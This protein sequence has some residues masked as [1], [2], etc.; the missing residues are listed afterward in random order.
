MIGFV[1]RAWIAA[2]LLAAL[3]AVA[4]ADAADG[5][6][7]VYAEDEALRIGATIQRQLD[8]GEGP[9]MGEAGIDSVRFWLSWSDVE[10]RHDQYDWGPVDQVVRQIATGGLT[11]VPF[12]FGSPEWSARRDGF[13]CSAPKCVPYAPSTP[14]TRAEFAEFAAIAVRRYG[15]GGTFWEHNIGIPYRPIGIWQVWNEPNL[16]AFYEPYVSPGRYAEL[17][18]AT[19]AAIRA[20]DA[21]AEVVLAGLSGNRTTSTHWSTQEYL[22]A[23]Y[24]VP[25]IEQSF[26]GIAIHP[27]AS[28]VRGVMQRIATAREIA[29]AEDPGAEL[30]VTEIGWASGGPK[31]WSLVKTPRLQARLLRRS[32][33]RLIR[34]T[35]EW[36]LRGIYWYA[37]R[38]TPRGQGVCPWCGRAGLRDREGGPKPAYDALA[39]ITS[40]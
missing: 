29:G 26:D 6:R 1:A 24:E 4:L 37:W 5:K 2:G 11:P 20:E 19:E 9:L 36:R 32:F 25:Q 28:R 39:D 18:R 15:P 17:V 38:D 12:I 21:D 10:S 13:F 14:E 34:H 30:W 31:R 7:G 33:R 27:Y 35:E 23:F 22:A 40:R 8:P 3:S 16:D